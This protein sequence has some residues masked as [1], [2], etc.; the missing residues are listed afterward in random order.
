MQL[1]GANPKPKISGLDQLPGKVNYLKG[2]DPAKWKTDVP[3]Y[4]KV[5]Y[6]AVYP[7]IDLIFY[8]N[9]RQQKSNLPEGR[10]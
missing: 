8:G 7:G 6:A 4:A 9:P 5:K 10:C 2:N 3:T 1:Q